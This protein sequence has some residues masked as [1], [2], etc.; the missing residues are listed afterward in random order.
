ME[1]VKQILSIYAQ[2]WYMYRTGLYGVFMQL[3]CKEYWIPQTTH[4][5]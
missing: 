3:T 5:I 4:F 2:L 1:A